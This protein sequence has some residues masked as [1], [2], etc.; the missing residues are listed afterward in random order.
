[1]KS[2]GDV[3]AGMVRPNPRVNQA[4]AASVVPKKSWRPL[5][6]T[7]TLEKSRHT[8]CRGWCLSVRHIIITDE[9]TLIVRPRGPT[10][11]PHKRTRW[12]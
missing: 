2:A 10:S 4:S 6:M 1:M 3:S 9:I 5:L 11:D 7:S 12:R 8:L